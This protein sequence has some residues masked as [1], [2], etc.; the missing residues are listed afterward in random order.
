M[1]KTIVIHVDGVTGHSFQ[2]LGGQT[3]L[4]SALTPHLEHLACHGE[5]GRLGVPGELRRFSG[6]MA[7]LALLGYD[8]H[9]WYTGP[10]PFEGVSLEVV[11]G[12]H[13]VAYLCH[14]VTLSG[15]DG[16]GDG[17]KLGPHLLMSDPFGGGVETEEA[18]ELIDAINEQLV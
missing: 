18:R 7:L 15:Q 16:W 5:V 1:R 6:E 8:P 17:K 12:A 2:E 11:L 4:Q 3:L 13:D 14:L 10:G 9:K